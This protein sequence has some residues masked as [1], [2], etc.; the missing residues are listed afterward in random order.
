MLEEWRALIAIFRSSFSELDKFASA[1]R[2]TE[3]KAIAGTEGWLTKTIDD[4]R[5]ELLQKWRPL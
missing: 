3:T 2:T 4:A 5:M 1:V